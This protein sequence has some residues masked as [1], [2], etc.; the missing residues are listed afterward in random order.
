MGRELTMTE[1]QEKID[2]LNFIMSGGKK[3]EYQIM[4][5]ALN[6]AR[7]S[8]NGKADSNTFSSIAEV[9]KEKI[10][11]II[12]QDNYQINEQHQER[13][14]APKINQWNGKISN[15][16]SRAMPTV[17]DEQINA[18]LSGKKP[19]KN[20]P[21]PKQ[22]LNENRFEPQL[23]QNFNINEF[24]AQIIEE[25]KEEFKTQVIEDLKKTIKEDVLEMIVYEMFSKD[26]MKKIFLEVMKEAKAVKK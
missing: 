23:A 13:Y 26:R 19:F 6:E 22:I 15:T 24:K 17:S 10:Q 3:K 14:E 25:I 1:K 18:L 9:V 7:S 16:V 21:Q 2:K 4:D 11:E 20:A 12:P 8:A 5:Q